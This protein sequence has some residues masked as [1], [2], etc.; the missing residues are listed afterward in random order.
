MTLHASVPNPPHFSRPTDSAD[1]IP[2]ELKTFLVEVLNFVHPPKEPTRF[3]LGGRGHYENPTSDLLA[4]FLRPD[5]EHGFRS[6]F[7]EAFFD[8]MNVDSEKLIFE[9][10][11][12]ER[13]V[14]T[15]EGTFID[16]L[17]KGPNL[18][19]VIENK[20]YSGQNNPFDSYAGHARG[21]LKTASLAILT[22][23]GQSAADGWVFLT[24]VF[25]LP[26]ENASPTRCSPPH[27]QSGW[28]LPVNSSF[29]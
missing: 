16:V 2:P 1:S 14:E 19:L 4:F 3:S 8:C 7:L 15:P 11:N 22:P 6:L 21:I 20:I 12:V 27:F 29:I 18:L 24:R 5:G 28:S 23:N 17:I 26:C 9:G 10:V 25:A 13:E